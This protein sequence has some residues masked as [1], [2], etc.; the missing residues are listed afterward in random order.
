[1]RR[2]HRSL[3]ALGFAAALL[4]AASGCAT[5]ASSGTP[6]PTIHPGWQLH[7][8]AGLAA[9]E[10]GRPA[11]A[12][13]HYRRA[14]EL[15]RRESLPR[16]ELAFSSYHLAEALRL[17]SEARGSRGSQRSQTALALFREARRH[18]EACFGADHP[19]LIPVW[20][21]IAA[22]EAAS[23]RP[24]A[25]EA[26]RTTADRIAV[27]FF[28]ASHFLRDRFGAARP[29]ALL[30]PLEILHLMGTYADT[31]AQVVQGP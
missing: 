12:E 22:L 18:F 7:M 30:H 23:G 21:R 13:R 6:E 11:E 2:I 20:V 10:L 28:P 15:A 27:R 19:V 29:A 31:P 3:A 24:E 4:V 17:Q 26:A 9:S 16:E 8:E 25:A 14:L 1:M 5:A